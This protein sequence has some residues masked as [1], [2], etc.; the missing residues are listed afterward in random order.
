MVV[1]RVV[2]RVVVMAM[3]MV[4]RE[5]VECDGGGNVQCYIIGN[6]G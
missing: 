1:V 5:M 6:C 2:V 4:E 3:A